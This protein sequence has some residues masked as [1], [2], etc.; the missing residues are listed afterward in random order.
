ML[1]CPECHSDKLVRFGIKYTKRKPIQQYQCKNCHRITV[2]PKYI[3]D[4]NEKGQFTKSD[5]HEEYHKKQMLN[6]PY[7]KIHENAVDVESKPH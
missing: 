5:W 7:D 6:T 4:R 3:P 1:I 2:K